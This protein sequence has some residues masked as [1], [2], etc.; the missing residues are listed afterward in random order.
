LI[1]L[2]VKL[3]ERITFFV[4]H[5]DSKDAKRFLALHWKTFKKLNDE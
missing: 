4:N 3:P 2:P 5:P 1:A